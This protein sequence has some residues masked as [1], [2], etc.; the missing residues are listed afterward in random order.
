MFTIIRVL[1]ARLSNALELLLVDKALAVGNL[2]DA[3]DVDALPLLDDGN[4]L[5]GLEE[6]VVRAGVQPDHAAAHALHRKGVGAEIS[7]V[8]G[9]NLELAA[10][11]GLDGTCDVHDVVVVEVEAGHRPVRLGM[12]GLLL[13]RERLAIG[14]NL[15]HTEPRRIIDR[16]A[17]DHGAAHAL[18]LAPG[19]AQDVAET[20]SV[21]DV[22][23]QDEGNGV[24]P[25]EA[26]ADDEGLCQTVGMLLDGVGD[27]ESDLRSI[28]QQLFKGGDVA[29]GGDDEN[30]PD[31]REH[32]RRKRV[33][34][35]RLV[36]DRKQLL[37]NSARSGE[38]ACTR[39][40]RKN[41]SFHGSPPALVQR[42][43]R[44]LPPVDYEHPYDSATC[45]MKYLLKEISRELIG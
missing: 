41:D 8:D 19:N 28:A 11:R 7:L 9:G 39:A 24:A 23:T 42:R 18:D 44:S 4:E 36:V 34:N 45:C 32:Q 16:I 27:R 25:D 13:Q 33:I 12:L 20:G 35:H 38:Q 43:G 21:E 14:T 3:G 31:T 10:R 22:V 29:R 30:V 37:G 6:A 5:G 17:E 1:R 26:G 2:L 15:H 40:A